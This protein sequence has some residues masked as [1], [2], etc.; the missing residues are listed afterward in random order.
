MAEYFF[1]KNKRDGDVIDVKDEKR[2]ARTPLIAHSQKTSGTDNQLWGFITS[3]TPP[4]LFITVKQTG[5]VI[6]IKEAG[7]AAGTALIAFPQKGNGTFNQLW[8]LVPSDA[9]EQYFFITSQ[10]NRAVITIDGAKQEGGTPLVVRPRKPS[11]NDDQL[12]SLVPFA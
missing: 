5:Q 9:T 1:I 6:D 10:L 7:Q 3:D 4:Y 11:D 2:A 12:W 8:M